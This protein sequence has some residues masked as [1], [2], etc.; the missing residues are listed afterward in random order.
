MRGTIKGIKAMLANKKRRHRLAAQARQPAQ[1]RS[2]KASAMI[3]IIEGSL[4][5][6]GFE[7]NGLSTVDPKRFEYTTGL[8][9][10]AFGVAE[11]AEDGGHLHR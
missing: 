4:L 8:V 3:L 11:E 10:E 9:A 7:E 1:A 2:L 6:P 5:T